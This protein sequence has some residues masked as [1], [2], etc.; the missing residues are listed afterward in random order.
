MLR[1]MI[2]RLKIYGNSMGSIIHPTNTCTHKLL[3]KL[4][5][6]QKKKQQFTNNYMHLQCVTL[7]IVLPD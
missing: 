7:S 6:I 1:A 4:H 2:E 5:V 3:S